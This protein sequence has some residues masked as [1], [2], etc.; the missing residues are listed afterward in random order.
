MC[1]RLQTKRAISALLTTYL[2]AAVLV[3]GVA[4]ACEGGGEEE[5]G[6][7]ISVNATLVRFLKVVEGSG[8]V[9]F[10]NDNKF[11]NWSP[12]GHTVKELQKTQAVWTIKDECAGKVIKPKG[13]CEVG[14]TFK[15]NGEAGRFISDLEME[16]APATATVTMEGEKP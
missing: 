8:K 12:K 11:S 10:K 2:L 9:T 1:R 3:P 15:E 5:G 16:G 13:T 6:N 14:I 4:V 7:H